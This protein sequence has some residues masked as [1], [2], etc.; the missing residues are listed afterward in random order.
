MG[1]GHVPGR[2][3]TPTMFDSS[4]LKFRFFVNL[5]RTVVM[6]VLF[7]FRIEMCIEVP[8]SFFITGIVRDLYFFYISIRIVRKVV[9]ILFLI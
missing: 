4:M 2:G 6:P 9:F 5:I 3:R 7:F 8:I 1:L